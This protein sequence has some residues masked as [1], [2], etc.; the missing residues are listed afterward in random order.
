MRILL[1]THW[2][3]EFRPAED[4]LQSAC[5][6]LAEVMEQLGDDSLQ[7]VRLRQLMSE[8]CGFT[9]DDAIEWDNLQEAARILCYALDCFDR[10]RRTVAV[11]NRLRWIKIARR[12]LGRKVIEALKG[13]TGNIKGTGKGMG[14]G[15]G[16]PTPRTPDGLS[17]V[18][19]TRSR[20]PRTP[21]S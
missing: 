5:N 21:R 19:R 14:K 2:L 20:S 4:K 17:A 10:R 6:W 3:Q 8:Y 12:S 16:G 9:L 13:K 15:K 1:Q 11:L 18:T 7:S